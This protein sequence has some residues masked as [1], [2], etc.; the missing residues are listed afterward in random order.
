MF[1]KVTRAVF[2]TWQTSKM[3]YFFV[4][5]SYFLQLTFFSQKSS[6]CVFNTVINRSLVPALKIQGHNLVGTGLDSSKFQAWKFSQR[7]DSVTDVFVWFFRNS[8]G[9]ANSGKFRTTEELTATGFEPT[10]TYFVNEH[11]TI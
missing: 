3:E 4:N 10:T 6:L 7:W 1:K 11:S 9:Q 5:I 8:S 2:R